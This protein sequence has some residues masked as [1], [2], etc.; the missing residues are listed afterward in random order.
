MLIFDSKEYW[1]THTWNRYNELNKV[2]EAV[3]V[4]F[5]RQEEQT[6]SKV[7]SLIEG[8]SDFQIMDLGCGTGR[9]SESVLKRASLKK[10]NISVTL[11]DFNSRTLDL[12]KKNLQGYKNVTYQKSDIYE[13]KNLYNKSFDVIICL[14][15]L[16]HISNLDLLFQNIITVLKPNGCLVANVFAEE[17]YEKW[18]KLKYGSIKSW[19]R[20][21]LSTFS[22]AIYDKSPN[23]LKMIIRRYGL[24]RIKPLA[25]GKLISYL[26]QYF[27]SNEIDTSYYYWFWAKTS[28]RL[29]YN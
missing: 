10:K 15:I 24:A 28:P 6:T 27:E 22:E 19:R 18:D 2:P 1:Q 13:I 4:E 12:A 16:H 11:I 29:E 8:K 23:I 26:D 21:V 5:L 20:S 25:R 14:D 3:R 7:L 9:I 17:T